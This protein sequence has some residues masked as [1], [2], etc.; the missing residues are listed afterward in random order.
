MVPSAISTL[1]YSNRVPYIPA[2]CGLVNWIYTDGHLK[3]NFF[4]G[5]LIGTIHSLTTQMKSRI[6][7]VI[8]QQSKTKE[9]F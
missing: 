7:G 9:V 3:K 2:F 4:A 8:Q 6:L 1:L 5:A